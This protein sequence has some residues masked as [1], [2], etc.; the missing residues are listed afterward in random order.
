MRGFLQDVGY[1]FRMVSKAPGFF[2]IAILTLA[3]GIGANTAVFSVINAVLLRPL[4]FHEPDRLVRLFETEAAPGNYPF[5]GPDY[6]DWK[7]QT[8][9][10]EAM[11]LFNYYGRANVRGGGQAESAVAIDAEANFFDVLG[12]KPLLGRTF[13][14]GEGTA[15]RDERV[16][17][18][19]YGFWQRHFGGDPAIVGKSID[20][21][22][23]RHTVVGVMPSWFNYP[24]GT[25]VWIPFDMSPQN[26]GP[27]GSHNY[28]AVARLKPDVS[29]SQALGELQLI[30]K[31]LEQQ[32]PD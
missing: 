11:A 21:D 18:L 17:I 16:A 23:Q 8:Q 4:P 28:F 29:V 30:A 13:V 24:K 27:R 22:S 9:T 31:R 26:L 1:F 6:L 25:E 20:L 19:S 2:A 10:L 32:Y 5:A 3:L 12:V 7:A 15:R 14:A